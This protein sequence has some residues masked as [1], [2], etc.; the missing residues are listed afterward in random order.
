MVAKEF[1]NYHNI[2]FFVGDFLCIRFSPSGSLVGSHDQGKVTQDLGNPQITIQVLH[3]RV[4]DVTGL[5]VE[6]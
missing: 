6:R 3:C 1:C 5:E 2:Q 4:V